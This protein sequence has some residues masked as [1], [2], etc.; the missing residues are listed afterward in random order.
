MSGFTFPSNEATT[1][2]GFISLLPLDL[3]ALG[4]YAASPS[5]AATRKLESAG[6]R[7]G[8]AIDLTAWVIQAAADP[9]A[10]EETRTVAHTD[11]NLDS[12]RGYGYKTWEGVIPDGPDD[13]RGLVLE[14][15][16]VGQDG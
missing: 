4:A 6:T 3:S 1:A 9:T 16:F 11:W 7:I 12:D 14:E 10:E 5:A 8:N 13:N 2:H 15:G